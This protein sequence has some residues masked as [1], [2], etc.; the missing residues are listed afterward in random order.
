MAATSATDPSGVEYYFTN[1]DDPAHDSGWQ[2]SPEY[3][4]SGLEAETT[5][6]YQVAARDLSLGQNE[7]SPS[8]IATGTTGA[9][10]GNLVTNEGFEYGSVEAWN[11]SGAAIGAQSDTA[12]S[13]AFAARVAN[14]IAD[15]DGI[16][17][18]LTARAVNGADWTCSGWVRLEGAT[19]AP[20]G[21]TLLVRD[22]AG[23]H[24][25]GIHWTTATDNGWVQ[26]GGPVT[27][28]WSGSLELVRLYFEGPDPGIDYLLDDVACYT[29]TGT[30]GDVGMHV[31][32]LAMSLVRRGPNFAGRVTVRIVDES[33]TPVVGAAV[34]GTWSGAV[35]GTAAGS[36]DGAG[37]ITF[38]SSQTRAGGTFTFTVNNVEEPGYAYNPEDNVETADSISS[39]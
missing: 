16:G 27:V 4:D 36:T 31:A 9:E 3:Y 6:R 32:D 13:G 39:P 15:W 18:D 26:L 29:D 12:R 25:S 2:A 37:E 11:T 7:T 23:D 8:G 14:R 33:G 21:M 10:D 20:V 1:L 22:Q 34:S 24:Y 19:S 28:N 17:Q 35:N 5:Y 38:T 30:G